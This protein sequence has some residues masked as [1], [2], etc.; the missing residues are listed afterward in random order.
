MRR[1][2]R[3]FWIVVA[4][5][6]LF[7]A[8]L[9][10]RLRPVVAFIVDRIAWAR[11]KAQVARAIEGLPPYPTLL[12]F[13]APVALLLPLKF[14]GL[15]MLAQGSWLGA[16]A[17]LALAKVVSMGVTAFIFD[18]T[19]PKLLQLAWFRRFYERVLDWLAR[20]HALIDPVKAEIRT[21]L[22]R[23]LRPARRALRRVAW[24][25]QPGR[26]GLFARRVVRLRRRMQSSHPSA[27]GP[28]S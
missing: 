16:M 26:S 17:T 25:V 7:E 2:T 1:W 20:A 8:W 23:E 18:V 3:P 9:W 14:L 6:F 5:V 28:I 12:V 24:L 13:L 4:L 11:L 15:W 19:R 10:E 21:W 27:P 22:R